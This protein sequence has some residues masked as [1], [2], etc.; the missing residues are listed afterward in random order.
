MEEDATGRDTGD[1]ATNLPADP[2][3]CHK[4]A[5]GHHESQ[6][7]TGSGT[8][9]PRHSFPDSLP[10]T[11]DLPVLRQQFPGFEIWRE[12]TGERTR[13]IARRRHTWLSPHTV[14]TA[15][16]DEL[17]A[18]LHHDEYPQAIAEDY[19]GWGVKHQ[20]G[21]WTAWCPAMTVHADTAY[22]LRAAIEHA[23][24]GGNQE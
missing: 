20:D 23:I 13:Y 12:V 4:E 10:K 11:D 8:A 24:S 16:P 14:V 21:Q 9:T 15:D 1:G 3:A 19:P 2:S 5:P 22:G 7:P 17:R 6:A 18:T